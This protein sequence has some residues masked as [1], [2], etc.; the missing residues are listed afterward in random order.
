[1]R[2]VRRRMVIL[3]LGWLKHCHPVAHKPLLTTKML[4]FSGIGT[5]KYSPK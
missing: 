4:E 1:M 5:Q 2:L 3:S